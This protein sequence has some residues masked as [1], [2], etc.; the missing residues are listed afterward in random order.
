MDLLFEAIDAV[1]AVVINKGVTEG[2]KQ[3]QAKHGPVQR[4][5]TLMLLSL[6][7][8]LFS[9]SSQY[10]AAIYPVLILD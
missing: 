2:V 10:I 5:L 7:L 1:D 9:S 3:E 6:C 8:L 4:N